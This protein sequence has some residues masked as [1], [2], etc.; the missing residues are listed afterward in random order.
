MLGT[1]PQSTVAGRTGTASTVEVVTVGTRLTD[2]IYVSYRQGLADA[3][4]SLRV[5]WQLTRSLAAHPARR[6]PSRHRRR[7]PLL[8][9]VTVSGYFLVSGYFARVA[10]KVT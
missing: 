8:V 3:E 2:D 4:G 7:L 10:G 6:L 1:M 5:A 9:Q